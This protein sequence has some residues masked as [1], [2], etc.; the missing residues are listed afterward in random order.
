MILNNLEKRQKDGYTTWGCMWK[1]GQCKKDTLYLLKSGD[2]NNL[3]MQ[4]RITAFWPDGSVKWT[5]HT[6][7]SRLLEDQIEVTPALT[8]DEVA[9]AKSSIHTKINTTSKEGVHTIHA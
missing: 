2:I 4:T 1:Q 3:P 8:T 9:L 7:D 6:A 5:A